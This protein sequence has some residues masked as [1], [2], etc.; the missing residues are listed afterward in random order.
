MAKYMPMGGGRSGEEDEV[1]A[2]VKRTKEYKGRPSHPAAV[3][4]M[5]AGETYEDL[6]RPQG[7]GTPRGRH[8]TKL[9]IATAGT[10][11]TTSG[12]SSTEGGEISE[13]F[14]HNLPQDSTEPP[15]DYRNHHREIAEA[16]ARI[17]ANKKPYVVENGTTSHNQNTTAQTPNKKPAKQKGPRRL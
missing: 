10:K 14:Y 9:A 17:A 16:A 5:P 13:P 3:P 8:K 6:T 11:Q 7:G 2:V 4:P 1:S 12:T 15:R